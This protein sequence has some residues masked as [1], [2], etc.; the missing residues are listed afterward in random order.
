[1]KR[2]GH[3]AVGVSN[4]ETEIFSAFETGGAMWTGSGP[5]S[6]RRRISFEQ[7]FLDPPS[8]HVALSMW[9]IAGG[10]NQRADLQAENISHDGFD[11][12]FTT[13]GDTRVARVRARWMA[14]GPVL[15]EEDWLAD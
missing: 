11:L 5:R 2:F 1:M 6:E 4:G 8:V 10:S 15:Y 7:P 14:I 3:A 9:D 13:W 12:R